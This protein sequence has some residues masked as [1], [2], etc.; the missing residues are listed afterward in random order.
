MFMQNGGHLG[1]MR[2]FGFSNGYTT[3]RYD[4]RLRTPRSFK[5]VEYSKTPLLR[6]P[7]VP[8]KSGLISE[9]D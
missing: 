7:F 8:S 5:S 9:F 2:H 6:P 3:A 4:D 1:E